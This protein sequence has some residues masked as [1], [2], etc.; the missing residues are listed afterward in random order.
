MLNEHDLADWE[1]LT[2]PL[3]LNKLKE[4]DVF[5]FANHHKVFE[6]MTEIND[7]IV[8]RTSQMHNK[9]NIN[10]MFPNFMK[11]NLW[12]SKKNESP[13]NTDN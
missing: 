5:T 8:A 13:K 2:V 7:M 1:S 3:Q 10:V 9:G 4:G 12:V 11:V 6:Y